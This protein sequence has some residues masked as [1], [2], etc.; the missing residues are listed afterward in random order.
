MRN[1]HLRVSGGGAQPRPPGRGFTGL[2]QPLLIFLASSTRLGCLSA[3]TTPPS[4]WTRFM[5]SHLNWPRR[6]WRGSA[7]PALTWGIPLPSTGKGRGRWAPGAV[8]HL[9]ITSSERHKTRGG[10]GGGRS[11]SWNRPMSLCVWGRCFPKETPLKRLW[12]GEE[13]KCF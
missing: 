1:G 5:T 12:S 13:N 6:F 8:P 10:E 9:S 2:L 4:S 7:P 11:I 3:M